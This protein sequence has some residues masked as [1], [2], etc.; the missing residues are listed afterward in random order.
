M[1]PWAKI[2]VSSN[3]IEHLHLLHIPISIG[4][5]WDNISYEEAKKEWIKKYKCKFCF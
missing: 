4:E 2:D 3:T 5:R 1:H